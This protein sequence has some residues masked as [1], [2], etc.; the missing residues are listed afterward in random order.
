MCN[1]YF[2]TKR[3]KIALISK[4]CTEKMSTHFPPPPIPFFTNSLICH[5]SIGSLSV[6]YKSW[7]EK[8]SQITKLENT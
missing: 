6:D 4:N 1:K 3:P 5:V 2:F 8:Y 7:K